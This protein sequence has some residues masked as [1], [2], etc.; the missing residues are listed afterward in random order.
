MGDG[1]D[2]L[3]E[4]LEG[5]ERQAKTEGSPAAR[6]RLRRAVWTTREGKR[7][8]VEDMK[9]DHAANSLAMLIRNWSGHLGRTEIEESTLGKALAERSKT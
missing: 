3:L 5:R 8:R 2:M 6:R 9:P 4:E 7:L 1:M